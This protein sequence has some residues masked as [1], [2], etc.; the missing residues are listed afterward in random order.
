MKLLRMNVV[1]LI[2]L[3]LILTGCSKQAIKIGVVGDYKGGG[4]TFSES[5]YNGL[6]LA[7]DELENETYELMPIQI[8]L[9]DAL[10]SLELSLEEKEIDVV[11]GPFLSSELVAVYDALKNSGRVAFIPSAT[12]DILTNQD[13]HIY[14]LINSTSRQGEILAEDL[15]KAGYTYV[16]I[17]YDENNQAYSKV[18]AET[19]QTNLSNKGVSSDIQ[20]LGEDFNVLMETG[21]DTDKM[22]AIFIV[23]SGMQSAITV[24]HLRI[25]GYDKDIYLS[26]WAADNHLIQYIGDQTENV[27]IHYNAYPTNQE[28]YESFREGFLE[29]YGKEPPT[30]SLYCYDIMHLI[31]VMNTKT[32]I[33]DANK[34]KEYFLDNPRYEGKIF[35]VTLAE[36]GTGNIEMGYLAINDGA[37]V[38]AEE[39]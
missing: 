20:I 19:V 14:R 23:R 31:E 15:S 3:I 33:R 32:D 38:Y 8:E 25:D 17:L 24:Q 30:S 18:L 7:L 16:G 6:E 37:F 11:V 21:F 5:G 4:K 1:Y 10:T 34:V 13:D 36:D 22:D 12:S 9:D 27:F 39:K 2:L 26:P 35:S 29:L 28:G